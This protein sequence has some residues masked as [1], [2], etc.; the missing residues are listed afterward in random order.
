MLLGL[1]DSMYVCQRVC[2]S[3]N[4]WRTPFKQLPL[5]WPRHLNTHLTIC[6]L[7][8]SK[9]SLNTGWRSNE[10][11]ITVFN[12]W[13]LQIHW[14]TSIRWSKTYSF[15]ISCNIILKYFLIR[16]TGW[17]SWLRRIRFP[18]CSLGFFIY[19]VLPALQSP[20][21]ES[22]SNRNEYQEYFL[23]RG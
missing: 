4:S 23:G 17:C 14:F 22:A 12:I 2:L 5:M 15:E 8:S 21:D 1:R 7:D 20:G 19:I 16:C 10:P 18:I 13:I 9:P 3:T 11:F 6:I